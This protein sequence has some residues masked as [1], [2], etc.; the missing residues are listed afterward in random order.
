MPI[1]ARLALLLRRRAD[2]VVVLGCKNHHFSI[3]ESP[4]SIEE[5]LKNHHFLLKNRHF[6]LKLTQRRRVH[7]SRAIHPARASAQLGRV[8]VVVARRVAVGNRR[9]EELRELCHNSRELR[10]NVGGLVRVR[11]D[12]EEAGL[13]EAADSAAGDVVA[14][15]W[16]C[17]KNRPKSVK[18]S[19]E[20]VENNRSCT[21]ARGIHAIQNRVDTG[22]TRLLLVGA[23]AR[24]MPLDGWVHW[25]YR[26]L[27]R[28][29]VTRCPNQVDEL[30]ALC[31]GR[32]D[33][34]ALGRWH[35]AAWLGRGLLGKQRPDVDTID[36]PRCAGQ[37]HRVRR[38]DT[39]QTAERW[40]PVLSPHAISQKKFLGIIIW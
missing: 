32:V 10:R 27:V 34:A 18:S 29:I 22:P 26:R 21:V 8:R 36:W 12:R 15:P 25:V 9:V 24:K 40:I 31:R 1:R 3:E 7:A 13:L 2:F 28:L 30:E 39:R 23:E 16:P 6:D 14:C 20:T 4:F 37:R 5:S 35:E 11:L 38:I 33:D 19:R 17:V